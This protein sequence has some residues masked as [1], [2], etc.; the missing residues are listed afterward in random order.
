MD[1]NTR[2]TLNAI[3]V[4]AAGT[5]L[6]A[7]LITAIVFM[8]GKVNLIVLYWQEAL[9]VGVFIFICSTFFALFRKLLRLEKDLQLINSSQK[10][11][12]VKDY[13]G[14]ISALK[15]ELRQKADQKDIVSAFAFKELKREVKDLKIFMHAQKGQM[16]E[17]YG[18]IDALKEDI[19]DDSWRIDG[20]LEELEKAIGKTRLTN[21]VI[22]SLEEQLFRLE[23][24]PKYKF[25]MNKI[26]KH[27]QE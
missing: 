27:Y 17:I 13:T 23:D 22:A 7:G 18:L 9:W 12:E 15:T 1:E 2:K 20:V 14:E 5:V 6:G 11:P 10:T 8:A 4:N 26:R 19:D 21:D 16:G 25:M 3:V 24:K